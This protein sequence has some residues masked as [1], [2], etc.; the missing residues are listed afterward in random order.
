M[1]P[2]A[3]FGQSP[4]N[5][6]NNQ[7]RSISLTILDHNL[8][9]VLIQTNLT[10]PIELM[11]PRDPN[12][13]IPPMF[14]QNVTSINATP[15]NQLFYLYYIDITNLPSVSVHFEIHPIN[16]SLGYLFIYKFETSPILN[17]SINQIDGWTLFCPSSRFFYFI[18]QLIDLRKSRH[19]K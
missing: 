17:S 3:L 18:I 5:V 19:D 6:D 15:H 8:A 9:E 7:S 16:T 2:L 13:V 4:A 14:L 12:M 11:I 1:Q 10:N